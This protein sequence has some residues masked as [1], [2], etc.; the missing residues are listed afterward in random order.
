MNKYNFTYLISLMLFF[1]GCDL[2][3]EG[4]L[5]PTA[6]NYDINADIDN[7]ICEYPEENFDCNGSCLVNI[8]CEGVCGG[9]G[10]TPSFTDDWSIQILV[11]MQPWYFGDYITDEFNYFGVSDTTSDDYDS[12]DIPDVPPFGT[13]W[14]KAYFYHPEWDSLFG[15]NFTQEYKSNEFCDSKEWDF[16]VE[17]NS[18]G[19]LIMEFIFNNVP[20]N[21]YIEIIEEEMTEVISNNSIIETTLQ[22]NTPKEFLIKVSVN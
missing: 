17:A 21:L 12:M 8:D 22:S 14:V 4:C 18:Q 5:D 7:G 2:I 16:N 3:V 6:C 9:S 1:F 11:S 19:P 15:D 10:Q 20:E 13:N